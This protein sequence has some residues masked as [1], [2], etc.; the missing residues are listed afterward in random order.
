MS[1]P[2]AK[3]GVQEAIVVATRIMQQS[4]ALP[5][6]DITVACA[7][8]SDNSRLVVAICSKAIPALK[9]LHISVHEDG[10]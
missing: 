5:T 3:R 4:H 2:S 10:M 8:Q 1:I 7:V 9:R 6:D